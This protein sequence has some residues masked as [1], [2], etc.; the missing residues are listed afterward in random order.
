MRHRDQFEQY[1]AKN[2]DA[3]EFEFKTMKYD[4]QQQTNTQHKR[5]LWDYNY[6]HL[7]FEEANQIINID[8]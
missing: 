5:L 1:L 2:V 7:S 8:L 6:Y 4:P 3:S